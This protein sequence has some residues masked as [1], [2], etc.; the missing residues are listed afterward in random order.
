MTFQTPSIHKLI[1]LA[2]TDN[3]GPGDITTDAVIPPE[4]VAGAAIVADEPLIVAGTDIAREIFTRLEPSVAFEALKSD[5]DKA[6]NGD[7]LLQI[8]GSLRALLMAEETAL[9]FLRRLSGIA[10]H[11]RALLQE[12]GAV[13]LTDAGENTPGWRSAEQYAVRVG[14]GKNHMAGL[15]DGVF[16]RRNHITACG[17]I[18]TA[19][20]RA[21]AGAHHLAKIGVVVT[22]LR[23]VRE[24]LDA[25]A[26]VIRLETI[27]LDRMREAVAT[28][29]DRALVEILHDP[30]RHTLS[31]LAD[32]GADIIASDTLIRD[33]RN[34]AIHMEL[35]TA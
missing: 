10:T 25:E 17:G 31:E 9:R 4:A 35:H 30:E 14:G 34:V 3:I 6:E 18:E 33:A 5:G 12:V 11:V 13:R 21:R 24:A 22:D 2:L 15:Y 20:S 27:S 28:I 7:T 29:Q 8:R 32:T 1:D 23:E 16:I 26:D 19:V